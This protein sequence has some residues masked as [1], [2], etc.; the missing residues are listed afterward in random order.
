MGDRFGGRSPGPAGFLVHLVGEVA[1]PDVDPDQVNTLARPLLDRHVPFGPDQAAR[2]LGVRRTDFDAAVRLGWITPVGTVEIDY[3]R[4]GGITTVPAGADASHGSDSRP[5]APDTGQW[6]GW[7]ARQEADRER[8]EVTS[9]RAGEKAPGPRGSSLCHGGGGQRY[10]AVAPNPGRLRPAGHAPIWS[11]PKSPGS[12]VAASSRQRDR[13][14]PRQ[15]ASPASP[16]SA[17]ISTRFEHG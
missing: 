5:T 14:L 16:V 17:E 7:S 10:E 1:L 15:P 4:Q 12:T 13:R 8:R 6:P 9:R 2:R 3:K 11:L